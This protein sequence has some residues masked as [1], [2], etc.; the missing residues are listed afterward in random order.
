MYSPQF[1]IKS[2]PASFPEDV[3]FVIRDVAAV[4]D[5]PCASKMSS[6][7]VVDDVIASNTVI[8]V[9]VV[10]SDTFIASGLRISDHVFNSG[11]RILDH[12]LFK[13]SF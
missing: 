10:K 7:V 2:K 4:V 9:V 11:T 13:L 5:V 12:I 6:L 1:T 3:T 8:L